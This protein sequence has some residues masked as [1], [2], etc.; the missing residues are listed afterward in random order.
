M[1]SEKQE[2]GADANQE[3]TVDVVEE[4]KPE[5]KVKLPFQPLFTLT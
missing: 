5:E 4:K 3:N 2:N 1:D